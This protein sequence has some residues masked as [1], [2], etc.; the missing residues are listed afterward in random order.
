MKK[1]IVLDSTKSAAVQLLKSNPACDTKNKQTRCRSEVSAHVTNIHKS[2]QY[3]LCNGN[4]AL[5]GCKK[6][7]NL[8]I[9]QR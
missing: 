9:D 1:S 7:R 3:S 8:P 5:C 2:S 6:L 4:H